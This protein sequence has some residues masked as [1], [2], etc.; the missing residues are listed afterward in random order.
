MV[1]L[2]KLSQQ[3]RFDLLIQAYRNIF[4]SED[5]QTV[6]QDLKE[7]CFFNRTSFVQGCPD[8][9]HFNE[10]SRMVLLHITN[11]LDPDV[12]KRRKEVLHGQS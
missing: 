2:A 3:E 5:G 7:L 10:G 1:D 4:S 6:L 8:L 12:V 9:S 11:M